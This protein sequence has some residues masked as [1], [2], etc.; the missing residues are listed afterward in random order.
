MEVK[1]FLIS[2]EKAL[3]ADGFSS[4]SARHH[5]LKI[6]KSLK[7]TDKKRIHA[8]QDDAAITTLA[9]NYASRIRSINEA[10]H[11]GNEINDTATI[12]KQFN[13][14]SDKSFAHTKSRTKTK[15]K[16]NKTPHATT[17][18]I[19]VVRGRN[20]KVELTSEGRK[21]YFKWM[22]SS[23]LGTALLVIGASCAYIIVY[24]LIAL[25]IACLVTILVA[26]AAIGCV[27]TLAGLIYGVIKLFSV[28]PEGIYEIGLALLILGITLAVS[29]S[30]YNLAVRIVPILWTKF[31]AYV[32]TK[33]GELRE[34]LNKVRTECNGE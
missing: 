20:Q 32:R 14:S 24:A 18:K 19:D 3:I 21:K 31:T 9:G 22:F 25:L 15:I 6:A 13:K 23:G 33:R 16:V 30:L 26:I 28:V 10:S 2:F 11:T 29:I 17:Q 12:A 5:T 8:M 27:A 4:E 7:D 1:T 34:K